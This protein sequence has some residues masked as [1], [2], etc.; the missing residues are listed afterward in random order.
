M[1]GLNA[2]RTFITLGDGRDRLKEASL[3]LTGPYDGRPYNRS[4]LLQGIAAALNATEAVS[5]YVLALGPLNKN[6]EWYLTLTSIEIK[7]KLLDRGTLSVKDKLFRIKAANQRKFIARIHWAP[8]YV[9]NEDIKAALS[10][11]NPE[12]VSIKHEMCTA[13]GLEGIATGVRNA[14]MTGNRTTLPHMLNVLEPGT[15]QYWECLVTVPERPPLCLKCK[16]IGHLRKKCNTPFCRHH[17]QYGHTTESCSAEKA[18][19]KSYANVARKVLQEEGDISC[20][21]IVYD[22]TEETRP[23]CTT[24]PETRQ[25]DDGT[26]DGVRRSE[27]VRAADR[28]ATGGHTQNLPNDATTKRQETD[29]DK[30][31]PDSDWTVVTK[32]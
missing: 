11:F 26:I 3:I 6:H 16:T 25:P 2:P 22:E 18:K 10:F 24:E 1:S 20:E 29:G 14:C 5:A 31:R 32:L 12:I 13:A 9:T 21:E 15:D 8:V 27:T 19:L 30:D 23:T 17:Q 4:D 28:D 7:D